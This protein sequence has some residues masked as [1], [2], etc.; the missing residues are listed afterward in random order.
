MEQIYKGKEIRT[1]EGIYKVTG[2]NGNGIVS[3]DRYVFNGDNSLQYTGNVNLT[4]SDIASRMKEY[5][6]LNHNLY[7]V[8]R[9]E[10]SLTDA[11]TGTTTPI[12]TI[13]FLAPIHGDSYTEEDYRNECRSNGVEWLEGEITFEEIDF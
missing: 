3:C 11:T 9:Y 13:E 8:Y 10:V 7:F 1:L 6:G 2:E 5:D 4:L 12:D